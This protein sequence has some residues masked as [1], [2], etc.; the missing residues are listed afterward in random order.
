MSS[1]IDL[2]IALPFRN[3]VCYIGLISTI[4]PFVLAGLYSPPRRYCDVCH[5]HSRFPSGSH[6]TEVKLIIV[7]AIG[8]ARLVCP[9]R[10]H[11]FHRRPMQSSRSMYA[12]RLPC[13]D[14]AGEVCLRIRTW[15]GVSNPLTWSCLSS[16]SSGLGL[17]RR[18]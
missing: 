12:S 18:T 16:V 11:T 13:G 2:F 4:H 5:K 9:S 7:R 1:K 3:Q 10:I 8:T 15:F 17:P 6:A 14:H